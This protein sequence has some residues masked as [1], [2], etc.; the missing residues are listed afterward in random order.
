MRS[1]IGKRVLTAAA[2]SGIL[3]LT[4]GFAVAANFEGNSGGTPESTPG[5]HHQEIGGLPEDLCGKLNLGGIAAQAV[6]DLCAPPDQASDESGSGG[7]GDGDPSH[8]TPMPPSAPPVIPEEP[9]PTPPGYGEPEEPSP[10]PPGYGEPEEPS[11]TP[12]GYG[13]PEEPSPTP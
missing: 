2:V 9:S 12:P 5:G 11:P 8:L 4:G 7:D 6:S 13:E 10:T 1:I 3:S